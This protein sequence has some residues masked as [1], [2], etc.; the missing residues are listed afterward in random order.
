MMLI[1]LVENAIKHG[2]DPCCEC[3]TIAIQAVEEG[4][5]LR[6]RVADTG[7]GISPKKG[8]GVGL[9]NIRERL[10]VLYGTGARLVIEENQPRGVVAT[11]EIDADTPVDLMPGVASSSGG[12]A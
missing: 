7:E 1:S 6:L 4:G 5:K 12:K 8:A 9:A 2:V 10:K 3:G 11:I